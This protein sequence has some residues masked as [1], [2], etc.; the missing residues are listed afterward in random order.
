M[1]SSRSKQ[2]RKVAERGNPVLSHEAVKLLKTQDSG[3]LRTMI[4]RT[5]RAIEKL[6]QEFV[7]RQGHGPE[8]LGRPEDQ[9]KRR[10]TVF[11]YSKEGQKQYQQGKPI[12]LRSSQN[13]MSRRTH[14]D[15]QE[16]EDDN[17]EEGMEGTE[18]EETKSTQ[19]VEVPTLRRATQREA[20]ASNQERLLRK[21]HKKEQDGRRAKLIALKTREK[22]L[23]DAESEL[24]LQRAKMSNSIGGVTK[25]GIKWRPRERKK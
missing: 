2:G 21:Q 18:L 6:E 13:T 25:A 24:E 9:E 1:L 7:L 14:E 22:D 3:Y 5:R 23:I 19:L 8:L 20:E 15:I 10:H 16:P 4:Q 12:I 11:V 17:A